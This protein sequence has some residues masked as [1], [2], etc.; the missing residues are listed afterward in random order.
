MSKENQTTV[1]TYE[2]D[3]DKYM[4]AL[5]Q[6]PHHTEWLRKGLIGIPKDARIFEVGSG[7]GRDASFIESLGYSVQRSDVA[8]SFITYLQK[9]KHSVQKFDLLSDDFSDS[10]YDVI[11]ANAVL[12]H[13]TRKE[14]LMSVQKISN[15]LSIGGKFI[16]CLQNGTGEEWKVNKGGPR[17]FCYWRKDEV[18]NILAQQNIEIESYSITPDNKWIYFVS[19]KVKENES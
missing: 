11:I 5:D 10:P 17:Y 8:D 6:A 15:S 12:L 16:F 19:K 13:F 2:Q 9:N 3:F 1:Q 18:D 4:D 14:F 7:S